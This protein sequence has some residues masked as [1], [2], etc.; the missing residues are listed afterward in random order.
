[1]NI[2][3]DNVSGVRVSILRK[4]QVSTRLKELEVPIAEEYIMLKVLNKISTSF[5]ELKAYSDQKCNEI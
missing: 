3:Y 1:M 5:G 2:K 4:I